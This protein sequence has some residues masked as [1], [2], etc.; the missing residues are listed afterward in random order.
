MNSK[1][2]KM[3]GFLGNLISDHKNWYPIRIVRTPTSS[4]R[5]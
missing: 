2:K 5:H 3:N 1:K 4:L